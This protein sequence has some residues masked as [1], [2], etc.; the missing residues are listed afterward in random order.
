MKS[1]LL[2]NIAIGPIR[3]KRWLFYA[4][5]AAFAVLVLYMIYAILVTPSKQPYRDALAEYQNVYNA[6]VA[7]ISA[8]SSLNASAATDEQFAKNT[9]VVANALTALQKENEVLGKESVLASG[10]GK[11]YYDAF[12]KQLTTYIAYNTKLIASMEKVR[13]VV[14]NCSNR[15]ANVTENAAGAA[16]IKACS[17]NFKDLATVPDKDYQQLVETSQQIYADFAT[18]LQAKASLKDPTGADAAQAKVYSNQQTQFLN[19]LSGAS[20]TFSTNLQKHRQDVDI[21]DS[22]MAL[23]KYLTAKSNIL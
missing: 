16:A 20:K 9:K 22:A 21:T 12:T 3:V 10:E 7:V 11:T 14:F 4:I 19:D 6:N 2:S 23:D 13:P 1:A 8:G 5:I 15:M 17:E 18:S